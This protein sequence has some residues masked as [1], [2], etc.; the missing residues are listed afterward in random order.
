MWGRGGV[1]VCVCVRGEFQPKLNQ[2]KLKRVVGWGMVRVGAGCR[3]CNK[4]RV[5]GAGRCG[6]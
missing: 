1:C 2:T 5:G 3:V 6:G 4:V